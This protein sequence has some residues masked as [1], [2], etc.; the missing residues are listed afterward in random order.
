MSVLPGAVVWFCRTL[1]TAR[2]AVQPL[3]S[4]GVP[5][6]DDEASPSLRTIATVRGVA[7][8]TFSLRGD[9]AGALAPRRRPP[10]TLMR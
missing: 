7:R 1:G 5:T 6:G 8:A 2:A 10:H 3:I 4:P 9:R